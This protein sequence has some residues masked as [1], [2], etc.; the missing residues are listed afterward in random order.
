[1]FIYVCVCMCV[2][3]ALSREIQVKVCDSPVILPLASEGGCQFTMMVLGFVSLLTTVTS[4]GEELGTV[5]RKTIT[6]H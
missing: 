2:C 3:V 4:L 5:G 1:M 6:I